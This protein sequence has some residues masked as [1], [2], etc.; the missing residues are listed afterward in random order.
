VLPVSVADEDTGDG[1][2]KP[3]EVLKELLLHLP[4][5]IRARAH[6]RRRNRHMHL[7]LV[8][9]VLPEH[10]RYALVVRRRVPQHW[11][12]VR[13]GRGAHRERLRQCGRVDTCDGHV[14][15]VPLQRREQRSLACL[16][17]ADIL[18]GRVCDAP[19]PEP[20]LVDRLRCE[21]ESGGHCH[22]WP[23]EED[24]ERARIGER[25][26]RLC[27]DVLAEVPVAVEFQREGDCRWMGLLVLI[28]SGG[29]MGTIPTEE[30]GVGG[31][32]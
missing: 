13:R 25:V 6:K 1:A 24:A 7:G 23:L 5:N 22:H 17:L 26:A 20:A 16:Q 31:L 4:A 21:E 9:G 14:R 32:A 27:E 12:E 3:G 15:R 30:S 10:P 28:T 11:R 2:A 8:R 29:E 19:Q 18:H